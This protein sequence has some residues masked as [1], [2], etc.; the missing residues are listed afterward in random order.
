MTAVT[1]HFS[2]YC[3]RSEILCRLNG[4]D[5]GLIDQ[6]ANDREHVIVAAHLAAPSSDVRL[7]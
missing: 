3:F 5:I 1:N 4:A 6:S 2:D 7:D